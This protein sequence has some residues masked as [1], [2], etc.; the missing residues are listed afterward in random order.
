M[1]LLIPFFTY[2]ISFPAYGQNKYLCTLKQEYIEAIKTFNEDE[3]SIINSF[4]KTE[5]T[6]GNKAALIEEYTDTLNKEEILNANID[7]GLNPRKV[8]KYIGITVGK[9]ANDT[10]KVIIDY[11]PGNEEIEHV[12]SNWSLTTK[13]TEFYKDEKIL[14]RDSSEEPTNKLIFTVDTEGFHYCKDGKI[15][16]G[17]SKFT[18]EPY[19]RLNASNQ[20]LK[21]QRTFKYYFKFEFQ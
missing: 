18:T 1:K 4:E 21:I 14:K 6:N 10:M 2:L 12:I 9:I 8:N 7:N 11:G 17:F 19:F 3:K 13:F 20:Y 16:Y 15:V 5:F